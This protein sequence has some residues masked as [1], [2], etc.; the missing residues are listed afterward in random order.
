M[1]SKVHEGKTIGTDAYL[2]DESRISPWIDGRRECSMHFGKCTQYNVECLVLS[3][4]RA[5]W[6]CTVYCRLLGFI[7][8]R[9]EISV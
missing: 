4:G 6:S 5:I 7:R 3:Y 8:W 2:I 1:A 9:K